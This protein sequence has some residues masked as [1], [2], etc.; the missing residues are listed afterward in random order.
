MD[1]SDPQTETVAPGVHRLPLPLP[2]NAL[3][4]INVYVL[5]GPDGL[6]LVDSGWH[7]ERS[8]RALVTLL[9][10][11]GLDAD[12]IVRV[13]VTHVHEDHVGQA[14]DLRR[15][16]GAAYDLG[17]GERTALT[18][19]DAGTIAFDA[20]RDAYLQRLGADELVARLRVEQVTETVAW[21]PPDH[22]L[23]DGDRLAVAG[24]ELRAIATPGHTRGHIS[25]HDPDRALFWAGDHV[26]P[27]IT[28]SIGFEPSPSSSALHDYLGS[29][30][31][32]R[33]LAAEVVLPAHGPVFTDL[34]GRVDELLAHH[35]RRLAAT[36]AALSQARTRSPYEVAQDLRWRRRELPFTQLNLFDRVLAT[37][38]TA[39]H[40]EVLVSQARAV[41][42]HDRYRLAATTPGPAAAPGP[43]GAASATAVHP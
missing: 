36:A 33:D 35:E 38:E 22:W 41:R 20:D 28:P 43:V 9:A 5:E 23:H 7:G 30:A 6:T 40:L 27:H 29:L 19:C 11:V 4:A 12:D 42:E 24:R 26:L 14:A 16:T 10:Q 2:G 18:F 37:W 17:F 25:F 31:R 3:A 15:R 39:A 13:L 8:R 34:A 1:W 21:E 32:V